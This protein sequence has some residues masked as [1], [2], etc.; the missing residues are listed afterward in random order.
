MNKTDKELLSILDELVETCHE[1]CKE[2]ERLVAHFEQVTG[3]LP[4][5]HRLSIFASTMSALHQRLKKLVPHPQEPS[6]EP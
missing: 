3:R 5:P 2:L 1:L 4:V 6:S